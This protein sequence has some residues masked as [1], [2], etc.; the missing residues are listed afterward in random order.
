MRYILLLMLS[1]MSFIWVHAQDFRKGYVVT[2][3][4]DT[5]QG[6]I[7]YAEGSPNFLKCKFKKGKDNPIVDY[8]PE[9]LKSYRFTDDKYYE[10][11]FVNLPTK[12]SK[13]FLEVLIGGKATV[14]KY[15][16]TYFIEKGDTTL[17]ELKNNSITVNV[18]G[19]QFTKDSKE[20]VK[21]LNILLSDCQ[22]VRDKI[23]KV[24]LANKS[25]IRL[26]ESYNRCLGSPIVSYTENKKWTSFNWGLTAGY[27][28]SQLSLNLYQVKASTSSLYANYQAGGSLSFGAFAEIGS[29]RKRENVTYLIGLIYNSTR[30]EANEFYFTT[31]TVAEINFSQ[32]T[33]PVGFKYSA[34]G[35]RIRPLFGAG[36]LYA[37]TLSSQS[38]LIL[39]RTVNNTPQTS[40][41][42]DTD[43]LGKNFFGYYINAGASIPITDKLNGFIELRRHSVSTKDFSETASPNGSQGSGGSAIVAWVV[44][45]G[46]RF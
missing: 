30:A 16:S 40:T 27:S 20:Y 3:K 33:I 2:S 1:C 41:Y 31:S 22:D 32:I 29:P 8:T 4:N 25:L 43:P 23:Q 39:T 6:L 28:S 21:T 9:D 24:V 10:T 36:L 44:M 5:I 42:K 46:V 15:I 13:V 26:A 7:E 34:L 18:N 45:L 12:K 38:Q 14:Y 17:I 35:G 11:R 37:R 19:Q